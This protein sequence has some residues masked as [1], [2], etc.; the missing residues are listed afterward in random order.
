ML[1]AHLFEE[2]KGLRIGRRTDVGLHTI[3]KGVVEKVIR[4]MRGVM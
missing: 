3:D 2:T 1:V 4:A